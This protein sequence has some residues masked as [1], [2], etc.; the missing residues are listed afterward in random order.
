MERLRGFIGCLIVD[1]AA[2]S[3]EPGILIPF[4]TGVRKILLIGDPYQLPSTT[5]SQDSSVTLFNRSLFERFLDNGVKPYF[6][7]IQYRMAPM[8]REFPSSVFYQNRLI[9]AED[10]T[11]R[12]LSIDN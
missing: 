4:Q 10:V 8:I 5:M 7:N 3:T 9:D 12:Y 11:K 1:E 2:Q 6:L